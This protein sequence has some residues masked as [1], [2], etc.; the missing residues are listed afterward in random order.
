MEKQKIETVASMLRELFLGYQETANL[1]GEVTRELKLSRGLWKKGNGSTLVK[2]GLTLIAVP[3]P[4]IVTDV[5]GAALVAA[6]VVQTKVKN[7]GLHVEDLCKTFL[8]VLRDLDALRE[9][10]V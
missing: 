1:M 4:F 3:D 10:L 9:S 8:K 2:V 6:S 5:V 7:S